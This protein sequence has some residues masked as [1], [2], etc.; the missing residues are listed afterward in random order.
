MTGPGSTAVLA[1][2]RSR[3]PRRLPSHEELDRRAAAQAEEAIGQQERL[4]TL[5]RRVVDAG[6]AVTAGAEEL[7]EKMEHNL[8]LLNT[9][10]QRLLD[11]RPAFHNPRQN[12]AA[13][14]DL[15]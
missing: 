15:K 7:L 5:Q 3:E 14:V 2:P 9:W 4:I 6:G 12:A 10:R 8:V 13:E 1:A 11:E